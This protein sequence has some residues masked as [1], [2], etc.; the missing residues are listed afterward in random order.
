MGTSKGTL[1]GPDLTQGIEV[2]ETRES[3]PLLGH[4]YGEPVVLVRRGADV[5]A[6]GATCS[7]YGGPLAE[8]LVVGKTLRCP[9]HHACFSLETGEAVG[10]PA[11][12]PIPAYEI[13]RHGSRVRV[14]KRKDLPTRVLDARSMPH[15]IVV[16]GAGP[17]GAA[18]VEALRREGY[19][20]PVALIGD[21]APGPVD[22]PNLSKDYLAGTAPEAW[23]P[24]RSPEFYRELDVD[25][26]TDDPVER[27]DPIARRVRLKSKRNLAFETLLLATGARPR[28]LEVPGADLPHVLTLRSLADSRA[29]IKKVEGASR[30]VVVGAGFIGL[31]VAASLRHREL[32][33][34][35]VG[36]EMAPLA[37]VLGEEIG[38]QIQRLHE[39]HGVGFH[40]GRTVRRIDSES[41]TLDDG[42]RLEAEVVIVGV[43]VV[44]R[45]ELAA[46]AGIEVQGG[47]VVDQ[48]FR[49]SAPKIYAAGDA[50]SYPDPIT[51]Q[52]SR[53]EHFVF[54]QR[55]AQAAARSMLGLGRPFSDAPF[56]W[57]QQYDTTLCYVGHAPSWERIET[58]GSLALRDFAAAFIRKD[59]ILAILTVGRDSLSLRA[60]AA[61][62]AAN[63]EE[64]VRL[65]E[66]SP[67]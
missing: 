44:P 39:Q 4:A 34:Q 1:S 15:S 48:F 47:I 49:T 16:V 30:I 14:G 12:S 24:L 19:R 11:L 53:V 2:S 29:I 41:V 21:E 13:L 26:V 51:L 66:E 38:R 35:V 63:P 18:A 58:R 64:L 54:A 60:E 8:G 65:F 57:S 31:E 10:G 45:T 55:Q 62:E 28:Q 67:G 50:V 59:R 3:E 43:G 46:S 33:V 56:F 36:R 22:R 27:V 25:L 42:S 52:L 6:I 23:I 20:G 5:C 7:H 37:R 40:L 61:F 17:A 32:E 9:W